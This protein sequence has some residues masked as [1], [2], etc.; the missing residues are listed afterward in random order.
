MLNSAPKL[1]FCYV[2]CI[3]I[4]QLFTVLTG[5][6]LKSLKTLFRTYNG[7]VGT[8][9]LKEHINLSISAILD[10]RFLCPTGSSGSKFE[11]ML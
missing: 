5:V 8:S 7:L 4:C 3:R 11:P 9:H 2:S 6:I 1:Y 10:F